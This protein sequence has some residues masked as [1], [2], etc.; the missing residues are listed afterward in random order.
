VPGT[1]GCGYPLELIPESDYDEVREPFGIVVPGACIHGK[2]VIEAS[3]SCGITDRALYRLAKHRA[4]WSPRH[5]QL[6]S[7]YDPEPFLSRLTYNDVDLRLRLRRLVGTL[8]TPLLTANQERVTGQERGAR[9][10]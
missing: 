5:V 1:G 7:E 3:T 4:Q 6:W 9:S 8:A 2:L 10:Q